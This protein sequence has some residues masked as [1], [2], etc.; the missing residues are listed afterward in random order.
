MT[1]QEFRIALI[2]AADGLAN[3]V[4]A[5]HL[6]VSQP[7]VLRWKTGRNLPVNT[8]RPVIIDALKKLKSGCVSGCDICK[9]YKM[10]V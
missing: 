1:D 10:P 6:S 8:L 4:V 7:T 2:Q 9:F 3:N 5:D